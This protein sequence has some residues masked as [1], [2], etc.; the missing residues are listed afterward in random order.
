MK[1]NM[2]LT[3]VLILLIC[4]ISVGNLVVAKDDND[5]YIKVK[6]T[7]YSNSNVVN[8]NSDVGFSI[9]ELDSTGKI[10]KKEDITAKSLSVKLESNGAIS[11]YDSS[12]KK[13]LTL[14]T[15]QLISSKDG[16]QRIVKVG[17]S[18]YRDYITFAKN[19]DK[20]TTIN[21]VELENYLRGVVPKEMP[22]STFH[23]EALKAQ[24]VATRT[25]TI[26]NINKHS[27]EG[28]NLCDSTHCQEYGGIAGEH[29]RTNQ[30]VEETKGMIITYG[31]KP[32]DAAYHS[33]SGGYTDNAHEIWGSSKTAYLVAVK[34]VYS[35]NQSGYIWE[36][37]FS[38][39]DLS[40]R[41]KTKGHDVGNLIDIQIVSKTEGG[42]AKQVKII[43]TKGEKTITG[44]Q[45]RSAV[46][47]TEIRSTLFTTIKKEGSYSNETSVYVIGGDSITRSVKLKDVYMIDSSGK[48]SKAGDT[49]YAI[50][51]DGIQKVNN[52][53][54]TTDLKFTFN[55]KGYGHGI[56]MSQYGANKMATEGKKYED[57]LKFYYT[58]VKVEPYSGK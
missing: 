12:N 53:G 30:A 37:T 49:V 32:I 50:T 17:N 45:F 22:A 26:R 2:V 24:A 8:L 44:E 6:L 42:R 47:S 5:T 4:S 14:A 35:E 57:I 25:Y 34:D 7:N 33:N 40:N 54:T 43:G 55:G 11:L 19:G 31:G 51:K 18:Q 20:L 46:G 1:R 15:N 39:D 36:K 21:Y 23:I 16:S 41:L 58:G 29:S 10:T 38:A 48:I 52:G 56:G 3:L 28:A 9:Y 13:L 27:S